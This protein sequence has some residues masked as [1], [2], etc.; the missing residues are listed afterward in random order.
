MPT[1]RSAGMINVHGEPKTRSSWPDRAPNNASS[2]F[3]QR[4]AEGDH[5]QAM[6][7]IAVAEDACRLL[8]V[9]GER[10][11]TAVGWRDSDPPPHSV[12]QC[13]APL[14]SC[15]R[16]AVWRE[17]GA[18]GGARP[19]LTRWPAG[20]PSHMGPRIATQVQ[21]PN[22]KVSRPQ[23]LAPVPNEDPPASS[24]PRSRDPTDARQGSLQHRTVGQRIAVH[25]L[26]TKPWPVAGYDP[27]RA[28]GKLRH[29]A[30]SCAA[31]RACVP[32][33]SRP[34]TVLQAVRRWR[35]RTQAAR[36]PS[37]SESQN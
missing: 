28:D 23:A 27:R 7:R 31:S 2:T 37:T 22:T 14:F 30:L 25:P 19:G 35:T 20:R 21:E 4:H 36:G 5:W 33:G 17:V 11:L 10:R 26:H 18:P 8:A 16:L 3:R 24:P 13:L 29:L 32:G 1:K 12:E 6:L 34:R 15:C 9:I